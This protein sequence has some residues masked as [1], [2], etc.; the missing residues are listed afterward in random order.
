MQAVHRHDVIT[1][2]QKGG[3]LAPK[4]QQQQKYM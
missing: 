1:L 3:G 2:K 4:L